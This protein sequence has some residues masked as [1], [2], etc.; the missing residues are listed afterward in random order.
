MKFEEG[1]E[2]LLRVKIAR[3]NDVQAFIELQSYDEGPF[4]LRVPLSELRSLLPE[5]TRT[6]FCPVPGHFDCWDPGQ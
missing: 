1:D 5:C 4:S 6:A 3:A 2:A